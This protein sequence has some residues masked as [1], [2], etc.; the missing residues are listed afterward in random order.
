MKRLLYKLKRK[1]YLNSIRKFAAH[2]NPPDIYYIDVGAR[3]NLQEPWKTLHDT[4]I[5]KVV[6]FEP[7]R[8][9][10]DRLS[11][12]FPNRKYYPYAVGNK[13]DTNIKLSIAKTESCSSIHKP[14]IDYIKQH[15]LTD[16]FV[17][18]ITSKTIDVPSITLSRIPENLD[19][20]KIDTQGSEIDILKGSNE[21]LSNCNLLYL[22][23]PVIEYN[24]NSPSLSECVEYLNSIDFV[25]YDICE[26]HYMD[27]MLVQI[28]I[29]YIRKT[30]FLEIFPNQQTI[31]LLKKSN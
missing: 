18:R 16:N 7:D 8:M 5:V 1:R 21:I 13:N 3:G 9:E 17:P 22:E 23:T 27:K 25:P 15:Y 6:G 30:K 31:D 19:F 28:D 26:V 29:L 11:A 14:N 10:F 24:L 2:I 20:I 4:N 12:T